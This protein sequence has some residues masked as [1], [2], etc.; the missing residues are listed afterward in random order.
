[1][2]HAC[3]LLALLLS[4]TGV[5]A[6]ESP[7]PG[8]SLYQL[9]VELTGQDGTRVRLDELRGR[10]VLISM[11]YASCGGICPAIAFNMRRIQAALAHGQREV[12]RPVMVSFDPAHDDLAALAEFARLNH[13]DAAPWIVART[14]EGSVRDLAAALGVRYKEL[15][16]GSFSHSTVIAVL[17]AD[18]VVRART[19][20]LSEI[21]PEFLRILKETTAAADRP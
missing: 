2:K 9:K 20:S 7:L 3:L 16:D 15:P 6:G 13:G 12:L 5:A 17:D 18:G 14:P 10:P 19:S 8:D 1:M 11:F 21:D 4:V